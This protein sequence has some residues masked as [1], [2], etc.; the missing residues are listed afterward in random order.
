MDCTFV[1]YVGFHFSLLRSIPLESLI[2]H[3][4]QAQ[5]TVNG[6]E[7]EAMAHVDHVRNEQALVIWCAATFYW[8]TRP[9]WP[10]SEKSVE[11]KVLACARWGHQ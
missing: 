11:H 1:Y 10:A 4:T 8:R 6:H 5:W 7:T 3:L 2:S 9:P